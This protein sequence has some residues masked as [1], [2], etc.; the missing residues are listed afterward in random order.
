MLTLNKRFQLEAP[1]GTITL[2]GRNE[3][4]DYMEQKH[5]RKDE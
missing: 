2:S 3:I 5:L 4:I 1:E